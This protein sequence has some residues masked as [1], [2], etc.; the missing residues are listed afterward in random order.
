MNLFLVFHIPPE[1]NVLF[2]AY[3]GPEG[4]GTCASEHCGFLRGEA[5]HLGMALKRWLRENTSGVPEALPKLAS[6]PPCFLRSVV[7]GAQRGRCCMTCTF[8]FAPR[9]T[10]LNVG[11]FNNTP[12]MQKSQ[13]HKRRYVGVWVVV[14]CKS[15]LFDNIARFNIKV[16]RK[17]QAFNKYV[18]NFSC[19]CKLFD[20]VTRTNKSSWGSPITS[21]IPQ[22]VP[23]HS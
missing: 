18:S 11:F 7:A 14:V 16:R 23:T 12:A 2:I 10:F 3:Q 8:I 5:K 21:A 6:P 19:K 9:G 15:Q 22:G 13:A 1:R 17:G 20:V 4:A